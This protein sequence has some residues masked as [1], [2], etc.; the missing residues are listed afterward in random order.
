MV[1]TIIGAQVL[2]LEASVVAVCAIV[3]ANATVA[4]SLVSRNDNLGS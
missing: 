1:M 2:D 3:V 4:C